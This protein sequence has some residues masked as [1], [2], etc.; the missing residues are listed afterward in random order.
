VISHSELIQ[1]V[2]QAHSHDTSASTASHLEKIKIDNTESLFGDIELVHLRVAC[3]SCGMDEE[4]IIESV[5]RTLSDVCLE[6]SQK[7]FVN[8]HDDVTEEAVMI[9]R[10]AMEV[11]Y[12]RGP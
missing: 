7:G 3:S 9:A 11:E 8:Y 12:S 5:Q 1:Q 4:K 2:V 10:A 6:S